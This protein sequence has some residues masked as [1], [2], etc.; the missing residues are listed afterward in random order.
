MKIGVYPL[1]SH[2]IYLLALLLLLAACSNVQATTELVDRQV[3]RTDTPALTALPSVTSGPVFTSTPSFTPTWT[4]KPTHTY[5]PTRMLPP[6]LTPLP[7]TPT[8]DNRSRSEIE[9][10]MLNL[11]ENN[12]GCKFPC[13][14]GFTPGRTNWITM[15]DFFIQNEWSIRY[16]PEKEELHAFFRIEQHRFHIGSHIYLEKGNI[17]IIRLGIL[18]YNET[19]Q[20]VF[21]D[22]FFLDATAYYSISNLLKVYGPPDD[23]RIYFDPPLASGDYLNHPNFSIALFY[24]NDGFAVEYSGSRDSQPNGAFRACSRKSAPIFSFW[25]PE[26]E[27]SSSEAFTRVYKGALSTANSVELFDL[28]KPLEDATSLT[29]D[30]FYKLF[31]DSNACLES[32]EQLWVRE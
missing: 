6:T 26:E 11:L 23:V 3:T 32:P 31:L 8:R 2:R 14:W 5:F 30:E 22:P 19:E 28:Y 4:V 12:G 16:S 18:T 17:E 21:G 1:K 10:Q 13:W 15:R 9:K 7:F 25:S 20:N 29:I 24:L 27:I